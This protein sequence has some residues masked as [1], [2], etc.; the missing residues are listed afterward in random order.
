MSG[1]TCDF[2]DTDTVGSIFFTVKRKIFF[3]EF[4]VSKQGIIIGKISEEKIAD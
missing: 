1:L 2:E 3:L 4:I